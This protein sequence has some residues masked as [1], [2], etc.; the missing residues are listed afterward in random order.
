MERRKRKESVRHRKC[1]GRHREKGKK[2]KEGKWAE[3]EKRNERQGNVRKEGID[4]SLKITRNG[5]KSRRRKYT[6]I[7]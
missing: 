6:I 2:D 1:K 4:K 5:K 7:R 3:I